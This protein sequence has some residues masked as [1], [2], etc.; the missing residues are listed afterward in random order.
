MLVRL[1]SPLRREAVSPTFQKQEMFPILLDGEG[2]YE[3]V[4]FVGDRLD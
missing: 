3:R 1:S 2:G 4:S